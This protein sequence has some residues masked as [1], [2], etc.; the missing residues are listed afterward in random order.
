MRR[1]TTENNKLKGKRIASKLHTRLIVTTNKLPLHKVT[2]YKLLFLCFRIE[3]ITVWNLEIMIIINCF[4][5]IC[6]ISLGD[7]SMYLVSQIHGEIN[8]IVLYNITS[9]KVGLKT[10][11]QT[12]LKIQTI[13][14]SKCDVV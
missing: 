14:V 7:I 4:S 10:F 11:L 1:H 3:I 2:N 6:V 12:W 5:F 13:G 9:S 8:F